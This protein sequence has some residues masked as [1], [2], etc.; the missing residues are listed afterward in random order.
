MD[1]DILGIL[2]A[3]AIILLPLF[4]LTVRLALKPTV[5]SILKIMEARRS[6]AEMELLERRVTLLEQELNGTQHG[7][8]RLLDKDEFERRL[9]RPPDV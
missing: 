1:E 6:S 3:G 2:M 8:Q 4:G 7:L 5:D 9:A